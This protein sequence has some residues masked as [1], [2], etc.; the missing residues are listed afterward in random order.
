MPG[1]WR[2]LPNLP[3]VAEPAGG[4][5]HAARSNC[6]GTRTRRLTS[7]APAT[8][9]F[10]IHNPSV[11]EAPRPGASQLVPLLCGGTGFRTLR[12]HSWAPVVPVAAERP[13]LRPHAERRDEKPLWAGQPRASHAKGSAMLHILDTL[14]VREAVALQ[15][16]RRRRVCE[17]F[18][19]DFTRV[20]VAEALGCSIDAVDR[21]VWAIRRSFIAMGFVPPGPRRRRALGVTRAALAA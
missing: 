3:Q 16:P 15:P 11:R 1:T 20:Q 13:A 2:V 9:C 19:K 6:P 21:A 10:H 17:M 4:W 12:V 8:P 14:A 5:R 7:S 18:M